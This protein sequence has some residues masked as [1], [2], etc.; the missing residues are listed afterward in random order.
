[1][2]GTLEE[3][4]ASKLTERVSMVVVSGPTG[5][6]KTTLVKKIEALA[7]NLNICREPV[8]STTIEGAS[9][10]RS[11]YGEQCWI[12]LRRY[13]AATDQSVLSTVC[14]RWITDD[15][16]VFAP[17]HYEV[18]HLDGDELE[19]LRTLSRVLRANL[20]GRIEYLFLRASRR[21]LERR[22]YEANQP[23]WIRESLERQIDLY[24]TFIEKTGPSHAVSVDDGIDPA[25]EILV[26]MVEQ[27]GS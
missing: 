15:E 20:E 10:R 5:V 8:D 3:E 14:D 26:R 11:W 12:Q 2:A 9:Q 4:A 13:S 17:L 19:S 22:C 18:G 1:M 24:E 21:T 25:F 23:E 16:E 7:P 27:L 6:G